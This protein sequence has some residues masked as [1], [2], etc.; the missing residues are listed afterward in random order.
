MLLDVYADLLF[1]INFFM[2]Y[3]CL[4]ITARISGC[5]LKKY[6]ICIAATLGGLYSVAALFLPDGVVS[7][8]VGLMVGC[9]ITAVAFAKKRDKMQRL[10]KLSL[11]YFGVNA[12]SGGAVSAAFRIMESFSGRDAHESYPKGEGTLAPDICLALAAGC[13]LSYAIAVGIKKANA[14]RAVRIRIKAFGGEIELDVLSDSGNRLRDPLGSK[15][16]TVIPFADLERLA[17]KETAC[18]FLSGQGL[19]SVG[20]RVCVIPVRTVNGSS[21]MFGFYPREVSLLDSSGNTVKS[22]DTV[23]A[24]S[25]EEELPKGVAIIPSALV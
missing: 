10:I 15:M 25:P 24:V 16:C 2:D 8:T 23:I 14:D 18:G 11:L 13:L 4:A 5:R 6:R 12:L 19:D 21:V 20:E 17:G 9:A 22:P 1:I 3:A 7:F